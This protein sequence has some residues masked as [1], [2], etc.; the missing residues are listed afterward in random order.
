MRSSQVPAGDRNQEAQSL[1]R[2][3]LLAAELA[4]CHIAMPRNDARCVC[5]DLWSCNPHLPAAHGA[6]HHSDHSTKNRQ[7]VHSEPRAPGPVPPRGLH[8]HSSDEN[9]PMF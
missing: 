6:D 7:G 4:T 3:K 8:L 2:Q 9:L 5:E 1:L